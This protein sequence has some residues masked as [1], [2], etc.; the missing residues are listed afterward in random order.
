[1]T[2]SARASHSRFIDSPDGW[3]WRWPWDWSATTACGQANCSTAEAAAD[4]TQRRAEDDVRRKDLRQDDRGPDATWPCD[5]GDRARDAPACGAATACAKPPPPP[6]WPPPRRRRRPMPRRWRTSSISCASTN[7]RTRP[8]PRRRYPIR[9]RA[10]S[11]NGS[12]CA[13]TTTAHRSSAIAPSSPPI[14][15]G[16]RRPSCAGAARPRCGTTIATMPPYGL[17]RK[18]IAA[19]RQRPILAGARD[20]RARR[21]RQC[22]ASGARRLAQRCDVGRNRERGAGSVRRV[23]DA[24]RPEGKD[25][26]SAL[27]QRARGRAA[28]RQAA[29]KRS[30]S[31]WRRRGWRPIARHPTPGRCSRRCRANCVATPATSSARSSCSAAK[32]N[33]PRPHS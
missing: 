20:A 30:R 4:R 5:A 21:P 31:R 25:G 16:R 11:R 22:G 13:A 17:V 24:G 19:L 18:R 33:S 10:N 9:W 29:R 2:R 23:A 14:R 8:R 12:S 7:P 28:R 3:P 1:M 6:R 15:A 32:R 27:W 26:S